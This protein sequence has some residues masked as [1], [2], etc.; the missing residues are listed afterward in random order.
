MG[1]YHTVGGQIVDGAGR[2]V[3]ITGVNWFGLETCAF[4]PH[5]LW[6]RNWRDLLDQVVRLQYNTIRL[7]FSEQLLAPHSFPT[8]INYT[9]NPDLRGLN[10]LAVM[11][12]I[13][14]GAGARGLKVIL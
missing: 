9:L 13:I 1:P 3:R 2:P 5:G 10:G 14:A 11:D 4:A 6:A 12:R 8:A 7:P